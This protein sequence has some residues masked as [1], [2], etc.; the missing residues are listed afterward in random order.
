MWSEVGAPYSG[1]RGVGEG[2]RAAADVEKASPG[3]SRSTRQ[4][5]GV[6]GN[7]LVVMVAGRV[8]GEAL[9]CWHIVGK[10]YIKRPRVHRAVP[11]MKNVPARCTSVSC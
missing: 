6:R 5:L 8:A 1:W 10:G 7:I 3:I 4:C 9:L 2:C 11:T